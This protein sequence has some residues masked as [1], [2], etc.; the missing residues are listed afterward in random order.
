[1]IQ[2]GWEGNMHEKNWPLK[3]AILELRRLWHS[4][5]WLEGFPRIYELTQTLEEDDHTL[6]W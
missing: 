3:L 5:E 1:M 2:N 6:L 4:S